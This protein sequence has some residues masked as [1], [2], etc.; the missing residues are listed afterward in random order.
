MLWGN[1][2]S[3]T[4]E[5]PQLSSNKT[6]VLLQTF[7]WCLWLWQVWFIGFSSKTEP[8]RASPIFLLKFPTERKASLPSNLTITHQGQCK[9]AATCGD[10]LRVQVTSST[11]R[12]QEG[13][14]ACWS[15]TGR[16]GGSGWQLG[17]RSHQ[18]LLQDTCSKTQ[19]QQAPQHSSIFGKL[20]FSR[21]ASPQRWNQESVF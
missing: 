19:S 16:A 17:H 9:A 12:G 1:N 10:A 18:G 5:K 3:S 14:A 13:K 4:L 8:G 15:H 7:V 2:H 20:T 6:S 21:E 11:A